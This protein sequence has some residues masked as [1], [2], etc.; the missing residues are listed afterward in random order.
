VRQ[1]PGVL[2]HLAE[3]STINPAIAG[4]AQNK[5]LD[6][7]LGLVVDRLSGDFA[8]SDGHVPDIG[9]DEKRR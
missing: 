4:R 8:A 1:R 7:V 6:F 5:M 2:E 9:C 3:V